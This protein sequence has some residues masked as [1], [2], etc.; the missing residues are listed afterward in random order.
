MK[1]IE[2]LEIKGRIKQPE[3]DG[4]KAHW[5]KPPEEMR[6]K[7][8]EFFNAFR[9]FLQ[10]KTKTSGTGSIRRKVNNDIRSNP[11]LVANHFEDQ[12]KDTQSL[13]AHTGVTAIKD[14]INV[15]WGF[16]FSLV[17]QQYVEEAV[18]S[19]DPQKATGCDG[20]PPEYL[21]MNAEHYLC[22]FSSLYNSCI[23][24]GKWP[25]IGKGR[26]GSCSQESR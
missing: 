24:Q 13:E 18:S 22:L 23:T 10:S 19:L 9:T 16:S 11:N 14:N 4:I 15:S 7:P 5:E 25:K 8:R 3:K 17:S 26:R 6:S 1:K 2:N 12:I 21:R 20:I